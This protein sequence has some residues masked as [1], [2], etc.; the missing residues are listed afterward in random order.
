[1]KVL[2]YPLFFALLWTLL[3]LS[4]QSK[5]EE[6]LEKYVK[7]LGHEDYKV[8]EYAE[9]QILRA[10]SRA[11]PFLKAALKSGDPEI[12]WR[13]ETL[14]EE[15]STSEKSE[16]SEKSTKGKENL[17]QELERILEGTDEEYPSEE[18]MDFNEIESEIDENEIPEE[19]SQGNEEFF[20]A[21]DSTSSVSGSF[22]I[23]KN[24]ELFSVQTHPNGSFSITTEKENE[25][26]EKVVESF[27]F[28]TEDEFK[29]TNPE[30]YR[31]YKIASKG[32]S[33]ERRPSRKKSRSAPTPSNPF[34]MFG[35]QKEDLENFQDIYQLFNDINDP[36]ADMEKIMNRS[37]EKL[38]RS[39]GERDPA[40]K[41]FFEMQ[42]NMMRQFQGFQGFNDPNHS[43]P[44]S[45]PNLQDQLERLF[46]PQKKAPKEKVKTPKDP[47]ET[48]IFPGLSAIPIHEMLKSHLGKEGV[49]IQK[50]QKNAAFTGLKPFDLLLSVNGIPTPTLQ[51]AQKAF[52]SLSQ[53]QTLTFIVLRKTEEIQL[54]CEYK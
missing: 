49:V 16:K 54:Q 30:L 14:L 17:D 26:G 36:N 44:F 33:F 50:V 22:T 41:E 47:T 38:F 23:I 48:V 51:A 32:I 34:E 46:N 31:R 53:G 25:K 39:L 1:M 13:A 19:D 29:N 37:M 7:Q 9:S 45:D 35:F 15:I 42:Q 4:A 5:E 40:L 20:K 28:A 52:N 6:S 27:K 18:E 11:I 8:R 43:S 24:G 3:P 2:L 21:Q 12:T 10:G